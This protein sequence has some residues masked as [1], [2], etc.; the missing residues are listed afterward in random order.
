MRMSYELPLAEAK[1]RM[2]CHPDLENIIDRHTM[3]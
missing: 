1:I 2:T 3:A